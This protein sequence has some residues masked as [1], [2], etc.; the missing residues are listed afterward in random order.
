MDHISVGSLEDAA[1][2]LQLS[3][4]FECLRDHGLVINMAKCHFGWSYIHFL[5]HRITPNGA[6]P[7]PGNVKAVT[8]FRQPNPTKDLQEFVGIINF[9]RFHFIGNQDS[10]VGTTQELGET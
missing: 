7:L 3:Q 8:T 4:L 2:K 5:G 9:Y 6:T 1:H 10:G